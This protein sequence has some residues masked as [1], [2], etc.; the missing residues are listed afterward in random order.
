MSRR[1]SA[2]FRLAGP[3]DLPCIAAIAPLAEEGDRLE[4]QVGPRRGEALVRAGRRA[5]VPEDLADAAWLARDPSKPLVKPRTHRVVGQLR[6]IRAS[7]R[8]D[9]RLFKGG[10][11]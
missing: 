3:P 5:I 2:V 6:R 4:W 1:V 11:H 10:G 9:L 8:L 7:R